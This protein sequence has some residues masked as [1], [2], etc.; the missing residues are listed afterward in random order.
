MAVRGKV[1]NGV[2]GEGVPA[3]FSLADQK[4]G[5]ISGVVVDGVSLDADQLAAIVGITLAGSVECRRDMSKRSCYTPFLGERVMAHRK[6]P[7]V[8]DLPTRNTDDV[9]VPEESRLP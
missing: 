3:T 5:E 2:V 6:K 7:S 9:A 1:C 4:T 8:L